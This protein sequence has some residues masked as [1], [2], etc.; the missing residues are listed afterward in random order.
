MS[1]QLEELEEL[2]EEACHYATPMDRDGKL[3]ALYFSLKQTLKEYEQ[4]KIIGEELGIDLI[5]KDRVERADEVYSKFYDEYIDDF[6]L[7][8]YGVEI[9]NRYDASGNN[10]IL[11]YKDY[12]KTWALTKEEL[13]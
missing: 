8:R 2:Y 1:K 10:H 4:L 11:L 12:G 13:E 9:N 5:T 3:N 6:T 7:H